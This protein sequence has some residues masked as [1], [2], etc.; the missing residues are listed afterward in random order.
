MKNKKIYTLLIAIFCTLTIYTQAPKS[1]T[2]QAVVRNTDGTVIENTQIGMKISI[3]SGSAAGTAVCI[4]EFA[5]TTNDYGLVTLE[6]GSDNTADFGA[7]DW[8]AD[9]YFVKIEI[10]PAG[11]TSYVEMGTSQLLSVP[12]ALHAKTAESV[13]ITG[14]ETAF[15]GWDK[16]AND[17]WT[18]NGDDVYYNGGNVGIGTDSPN[19]P[20]T[21]NSGENNSYIATF[22]N[23]TGT[24]ISDGF[25]TGINTSGSGYLWNFEDGPIYVGTNN[26]TKMTITAAGDVGIG[27]SA[28]SATLDVNGDVQI[29][30]SG[31]IFQEIREITGTTDASLYY[32]IISLPSGYTES[33]TRILNLQINYNGDRWTSLGY[34]PNG[35]ER[36]TS[37]LINE[38]SL[39]LYCP[40][41]SQLKN[42]AYRIL[43]MRID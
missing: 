39:Y 7:I 15:D 25:L 3:L 40:D 30:S 14:S 28:P 8:S 26:S 17:V 5:P 2:Y 31:A 13:P 29:G 36:P 43:L 22:N 4:E 18:E 12:Y 11:G 38:S 10:D 41:I 34:A 6:I 24:T 42:K 37:C 33:N 16:D 19:R 32:T 1:F 23:Y 35:A 9:D 20:L 21:I 27:T